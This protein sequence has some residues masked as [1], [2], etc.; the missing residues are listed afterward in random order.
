V[1]RWWYVL[2][3]LAKSIPVWKFWQPV[4]FP[5]LGLC[6]RQR[7]TASDDKIGK[8]AGVVHDHPSFGKSLCVH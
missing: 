2:T 3:R 1:Q 6:Y 8:V 7:H 4:K 5:A